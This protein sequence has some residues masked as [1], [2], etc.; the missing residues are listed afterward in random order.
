MNKI[1][2]SETQ[3]KNIERKI[4]NL[5]LK[6]LNSNFMFN[7]TNFD[8]DYLNLLN[9]YLFNDFYYDDELGLRKI[10]DIEKK[11]LNNYLNKIVYLC[12]N[13]PDNILEILKIIEEIW[14]YQP[15]IVGNTRT[16]LGFLSILNDSFNLNLYIDFDREIRRGE[17]SFELGYI[18]N[19]N[20]LT[21]HK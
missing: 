5:K 18:V 8:L 21:K 2:R 9:E 10:D 17:E 13:D 19:Q 1:C 4:V 7:K 14:H 11:F 12:V 15:F 20:R 3:L 6:L 16:L